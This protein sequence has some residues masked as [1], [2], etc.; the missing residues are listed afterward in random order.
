M[1]YSNDEY[2]VVAKAIRGD[3][4]AYESLII[5][6]N[7]YFYKIAYLY[8]RNPH[9]AM[10]VVQES[11]YKGFIKINQLKHPEKFVTWMNSIVINQALLHIRKQKKFDTINENNETSDYMTPAL[12][13]R[14]DLFKALKKLRR[15]YREAIVLKFFYDK[16]IK[17]ISQIMGTSENTI[18]TYL[19]RGKIKLKEFLKEDYFED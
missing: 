7:Q 18:K 17:E 14:L 9:D 11:V 13:T 1:L 8:T 10:D 6:Y 19:S 3:S 5:K 2:S 16:P 12:E 15:P 4:T